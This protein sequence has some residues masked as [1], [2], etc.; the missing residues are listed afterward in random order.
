MLLLAINPVFKFKLL[1]KL[2]LKFLF[3][4]IVWNIRIREVSIHNCNSNSNLKMFP[5]VKMLQ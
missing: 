2:L 5:I 4:L 3:Q 1:F